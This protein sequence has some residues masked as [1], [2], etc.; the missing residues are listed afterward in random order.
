MIANIGS[1][2]LMWPRSRNAFAFRRRTYW[3]GLAAGAA[4]GWV[5]LGYV[6]GCLC[7]ILECFFCLLVLTYNFLTKV[8]N[9]SKFKVECHGTNNQQ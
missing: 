4:G 3:T 2:I 5:D 7:M 6:K 1:I 9:V 8:E